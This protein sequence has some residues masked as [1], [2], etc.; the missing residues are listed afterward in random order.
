MADLDIP[1]LVRHLRARLGLT[2]EQFAREVGV[3]FSTV[4]QWENG[5][6]RPQPFLVQRLL[7]MQ[8]ALGEGSPGRLRREEARTFKERWEDVH[9]A[10]REELATTP[11]AHKFRQL[12]ALMASAGQLGWTGAQAA[13]EDLVRRRW[14]RLRRELHA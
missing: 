8:S 11:L 2:Q 9:T 7:E 5:R 6:R 13:D 12:A 1:A 14:A 3:T 10:E 4:N